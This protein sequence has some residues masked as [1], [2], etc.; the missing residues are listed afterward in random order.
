MATK[1]NFTYEGK[2]QQAYKE[3]SLILWQCDDKQWIVLH[4]G[5]A[6]MVHKDK[7]WEKKRDA[8]AYAQ[9]L[10][11]YEENGKRIIWDCTSYQAFYQINDEDF[12]VR[13]WEKVKD[14]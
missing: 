10:M 5:T 13:A 11:D 4:E 9:A 1:I 8:M 6:M 2:T 7:S 3:G 12:I 14:M